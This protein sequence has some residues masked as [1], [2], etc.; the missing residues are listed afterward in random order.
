MDFVYLNK[1]YYNALNLDK[2]QCFLNNIRKKKKNLKKLWKA[3]AN[4]EP[5]IFRSYF[6]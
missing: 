5:G 2:Y 3:D 1:D 4:S 6:F